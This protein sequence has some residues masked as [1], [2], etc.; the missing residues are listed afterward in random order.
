MFGKQLH[1]ISKIMNNEKF[2]NLTP[3][4]IYLVWEVYSLLHIALTFLELNPQRI[5]WTRKVMMSV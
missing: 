5:A 3:P 2:H 1:H 4:C